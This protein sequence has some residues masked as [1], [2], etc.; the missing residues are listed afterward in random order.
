[1]PGRAQGKSSEARLRL[2]RGE[3]GN[4]SARM[5]RDCHRH[6][7]RRRPFVGSR[8]PSVGAWSGTPCIV[9]TRMRIQS[10]GTPASLRRA[11]ILP[12]CRVPKPISGSKLPFRLPALAGHCSTRQSE[13]Q[14]TGTEVGT[15]TRIAAH[16][17]SPQHSAHPA[18]SH[19]TPYRRTPFLQYA[20][21][22]ARLPHLRRCR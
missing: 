11:S 6:A 4:V 10:F 16:R 5:G 9:S 3:A 21:V 14:W 2:S 7:S 17:S 18:E 15:L 12:P 22:V 8:G 1:V 20:H 13:L 19:R